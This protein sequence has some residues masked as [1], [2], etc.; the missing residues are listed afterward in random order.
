MEITWLGHSCFRLKGRD[1]TILTDPYGG[2]ELG[3]PPLTASAN[4]VTV[5]NDHPHHSA[6]DVLGG[7]PRVFD[8]PGEYETGGVMVWGVRTFRA[9]KTAAGL[10]AKN[11]AFLI[12]LEELRICHLGDLGHALDAEQL[13]E[14]KDCDV[15]LVPVGGHCTIGASQAAEIVAQIEPKV[16]VPMHYGTAETSGWV[17][18]DPLE[19]FSREMGAADVVPQNRLSVTRASLQLVG[20]LMV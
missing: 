20:L 14:I 18:L 1:V 17:E 3:Y 13:R 19:R 2:S 15:L 11:C 16:V 8:G 6:V 7:S 12:Q 4:V 10:P 5:S 9:E